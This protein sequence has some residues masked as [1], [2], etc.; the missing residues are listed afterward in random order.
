MSGTLY[1]AEGNSILREEDLPPTI[2][3]WTPG[4][5]AMIVRA[6]DL[7]ILSFE[8]LE[9]KYDVDANTLIEWRTTLQKDGVKGLRVTRRH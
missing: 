3:R 5:K 2:T 8:R 6:V 4:R 9:K 7:G 1:D